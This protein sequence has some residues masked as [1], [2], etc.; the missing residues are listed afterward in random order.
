MW[1]I[2]RTLVLYFSI[3]IGKPGKQR[4]IKT[5]VNLTMLFLLGFQRYI[6]G[7]LAFP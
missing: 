3:V 4:S 6:T 5:T 2:A 7:I 1:L